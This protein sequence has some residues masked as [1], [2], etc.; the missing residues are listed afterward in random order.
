MKQLI[1]CISCGILLASCAAIQKQMPMVKSAEQARD[2]L[3]TEL[4][5]SKD[6]IGK[7]E[8]Q[9][10]ALEKET[11]DLRAELLTKEKHITQLTAQNEEYK[12][13]NDNLTTQQA[14]TAAQ[15]AAESKAMLEDLQRVRE[16]LYA[17]QDSLD[18]LQRSFA[19]KT[20][21][22]EN[23]MR[24]MG[25][26]NEEL[27]LKNRKIADMEQLIHRQDSANNALRQKIQRALMSFEGQG[28]TIEQR[29][30]KIYVVLEESLLF[31]VGQST[32]AENGQNALKQLAIVL[33]QNPDIDITI[34]GHTDN[35]GGSKR[36]W[37]LS[38]E[39]ALAISQI[40]L[41]NSKIE[42][43]RIIVSGKG[44]YSP[45]ATNDTPEG[46]AKNRRSEIILTPDLQEI[47][48]I[49]QD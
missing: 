40:L 24:E 31:K 44:Q 20:Q 36:N 27:S 34:E 35:T 46:R 6:I 23:L 10:A 17:R 26:K 5:V 18:V 42:G 28:L 7:L 30:G 49:I 25:F 8:E 33:A 3:A 48:E 9:N 43:A 45:I 4:A 2:S 22:L 47:F 32:V 16:T 12:R 41:N 29:G 39:R 1:F 15:A 21:I 14:K 37:E 11:V 38:T 19:E 13:L